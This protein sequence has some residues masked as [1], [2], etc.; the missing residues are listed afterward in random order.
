[1]KTKTLDVVKVDRMSREV[2]IELMR[3]NDDYDLPCYHCTNSDC[4]HYDNDE[5]TYEWPCSECSQNPEAE[6]AFEGILGY[7]ARKTVKKK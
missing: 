2:T 3:R 5:F 7:D 6:S 1:M 4:I